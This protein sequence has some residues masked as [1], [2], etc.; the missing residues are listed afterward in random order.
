MLHNVFTIDIMQTIHLRRNKM[1]TIKDVA[2]LA[3]V[4][5]STV[6]YVLN[7]SK[8]LKKETQQRVLDAVETLEY[9]PNLIARSLKTRKTSTIGIIVPDIANAFFTEIIRGIE[10]ISEQ[11]NHNV[12][13]CNT[14]ENPEKEE[15]YLITLL[16]RDIDGLI[17]VG[18]GKNP[19][20]LSNIKDISIVVVDRRLGNAFSSVVVNNEKGGYIAASHLLERKHEEIL[21]LTGPLSINTYFERLTGYLRAL[22]KA[23]M[24]RNEML[25]HECEVSYDGGQRIM[26]EIL[27]QEIDF[28]SIFATNDLIALGAYNTLLQN[29]VRIP[30]DILLIGFDDIPTAHIITPGLTTVKQ[31]TYQIGTKAS[32][33][34]FNQLY[35]KDQQVEHIILEPELVIRQTA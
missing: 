31:P 2:K 22:Q 34:L 30:D 35:N 23:G 4:A 25:I 9:K 5:T 33:L 27:M 29:N 28:G 3:G 18:T 19:R 13:L 17:F 12:I 8:S 11:N 14:Y 16:S 20:I 32:T 21:L 10:D 1:A 24:N 15:K 26:Q 6:S 7:N